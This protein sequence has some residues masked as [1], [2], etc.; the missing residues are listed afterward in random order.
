VADNGVD[1]GFESA[2][3]DL[4]SRSMIYFLRERNIPAVEGITSI[5][6]K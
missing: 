6:K 1:D 2:M 4:C 3:P 5:P